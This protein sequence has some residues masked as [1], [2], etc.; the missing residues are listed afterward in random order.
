MHRHAYS[1]AHDK[2]LPRIPKPQHGAHYFVVC[3]LLLS[4]LQHWKRGR[5][6]KFF[7]RYRLPCSCGCCIGPVS[8][9]L[10]GG[11]ALPSGSR[12]RLGIADQGSN[13]NNKLDL[14]F[15]RLRAPDP[16]RYPIS[17]ACT[18]QLLCAPGTVSRAGAC[19]LCSPGRYSGLTGAASCTL[20][21]VVTP[22]SGAG[23]IS[24]GNCS[25][26]AVG[27]EGG[28]FGAWWGPG[29]LC[30]AGH[31]CNASSQTMVSVPTR[32]TSPIARFLVR[33]SAG[34]LQPRGG[35]VG[36]CKWEVG[37]VYHKHSWLCALC[38]HCFLRNHRQFLAVFRG[39]HGLRDAQTRC[40]PGHFSP[41][42]ETSCSPCPFGTYSSLGAV[43]SCDP[44]PT[45][46]PFS[47]LRTLSTAGCMCPAGHAC[48][49]DA[50]P[51]AC[52]ADTYSH[53]GG[54]ACVPC[55][56]FTSSSSGADTCLPKCPSSLTLG[57]PYVNMSR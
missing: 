43:A 10:S 25:S 17:C 55:P 56:Q 42:G 51:V 9:P 3:A 6:V 14:C 39:C 30:P 21:P 2:V 5:P 37:C 23:A 34:E 45:A 54:G 29:F 35:G 52:P 13:T 24:G 33:V 27:C 53:T 50:D 18:L 49:D 38:V 31:A 7:R 8:C 46:R 40:S 11:L 22:Y 28:I 48:S 26:C 47:F 41:V 57:N 36:R 4:L 32:S 20:C 1:S 16:G 44:C 15:A 12:L 19:E